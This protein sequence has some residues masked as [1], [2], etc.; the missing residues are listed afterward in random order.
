METFSTEGIIL[1]TI[2]FKDYDKILSLFTPD[3][4]LVKAILYRAR[5]KGKTPVEPLVLGD[6]LLSPARGELLPCR[7]MSVQN[8]YLSLRDHYHQLEAGCD[9][10]QAILQ[11]QMVEKPAP[12]LYKLLKYYLERLGLA[13]DPRALAAS[14]RLKILNHEG[15]LNLDEEQHEGQLNRHFFPDELTLIAQLTNTRSFAELAERVVSPSLHQKVKDF[16]SFQLS[17]S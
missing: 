15:L 9:L 3:H 1:H 8:R 6:F 16:F 14:F 11:S 12:D 17:Q 7:E 13:K 4:G 5:A 10:V 2:D